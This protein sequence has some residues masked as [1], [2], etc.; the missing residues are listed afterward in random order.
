MVNGASGERRERELKFDVPADWELPDPCGL[1]TPEG[2]VERQVVR[3]ETTYFDTAGRDLLRNRL[4]L[5]RRTGDIDAGWQ[6]KVPA[7]D[8]RTE[9][10][11]AS[12]GSRVRPRA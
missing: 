11:L 1:T 6:L 9:I 8:A 2:S 12:E 4:T 3:L 10:R 7:G 5:R